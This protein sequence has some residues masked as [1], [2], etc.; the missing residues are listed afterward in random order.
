MKAPRTAFGLIFLTLTVSA[1]AWGQVTAQMHGTVQDSTGAAVPAATITVTQTQT[2]A[3]RTASSGANGGYVFT[4]L[5]IGPYRMEVSKDGFN[6]YVQEGIVLQ[7]NSDPLITVP[8]VVGTVNEQVLV[9]A[10]ATQVE[11]RASGVGQ[12]VENQRILELP[13]NGRNVTDLITLAGA[14]VETQET[15]DRFFAGSPFIGIGGGIPFGTSYTLDGANNI[16]FLTGVTMP[17]PFP[18]AV[19]EF[20]VET[21]GLTAEK[22]MSSSVSMVTKSGTNALHGDLFYFIRNGAT[23]GRPYSSP[24]DDNLKRNQFGG[25]IGGAIVPNRLFFFGGY[26][27]TTIRQFVYNNPTIIATPDMIRGDFTAFASPAC[28]GRQITM[29]GG[30]V[31]NKIDPAKFSPPAVV[32]AQALLDTQDSPPDQC[33]RVTYGTPTSRNDQQYVAKIDYQVSDRHSMFGRFVTSPQKFTKSFDLTKNLLTAGGTGTDSLAHSYTFGD[34]FVVNPAMVNAFRMAFNRVGSGRLANKW[35][36]WCTAGVKNFYCEPEEEFFG[37]TTVVGGFRTGQIFWN[38]SGWRPTNYAI[39][40][41]LNWV[42]GAHQMTIGFGAWQGRVYTRADYAN[43][44]QMVFNPQ[45]TGLGMGDFMTGN[46][47][48]LFQGLPN[49]HQVK[50]NSFD[51]YITDTWK[52]N[53]RLTI[54]AGLRYEPFLPQTVLNGA[55]YNFDINRFMA[56]TKSSVFVNAPAGFYYP[57]D[58][59]FPGM[60]GQ[61]RRWNQFAPR[62]GFAFDPTGDGRTSLRASWALGY[63]FNSGIWREDASGSNPWGGRSIYTRLPGGLSDPWNGY[64]GGNPYPYTVNKNVTFPLRGAFISAPYDFKTPNSYSWNVNLQHQLGSSW[65]LS[66][67]YMGNRTTHIWGYNA[68][69]AADPTVS[70]ASSANTDARRRLSLLNAAE[71]DFVG[72]MSEFDDGGVQ[73]YHAMLLSIQRRFSRGFS[74]SGNYT[75]SHCIGPLTDI[76]SNGPPADETWTVVGNREFDRGN[77]VADRRH[78]FN[79]TAVAETPRFSGATMRALGSGWKI[80]G[81]YRVTSG[82][83]VSIIM[84][85]DR[86]LTGITRQRPDQVMSDVILDGSG[87]YG[88]QYFNPAAFA[89]QTPGTFGNIGYNSV[90][91]PGWWNLDMSLSRAFQIRERVRFELRGEAFNVTNSYRTDNPGS[92]AGTPGANFGTWDNTAQ[93]GKILMVKDS[94][95]MQFAMKF[96]F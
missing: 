74:V 9:E 92:G 18:D 71:G 66:A 57:G 35:F 5:P 53:Q 80:S 25:T 51:L 1:I 48:T 77:C 34:T 85:T 87:H 33:G 55:V 59:G 13:L 47:F 81:I 42:R 58:P 46:M 93:F 68:I 32:V 2:G 21:S 12:V 8:L 56:G 88:S 30:F 54:N 17:V 64:P 44:A 67:T 91:A 38:T 26:Q 11:T 86:Q 3:V 50:Q 83:P 19:E 23:N 96:V 37:F 49:V 63:V 94:R 29:R 52:V 28:N 20:K 6:K 43:P 27:G 69:N 79:L 76:N 22:G 39:N 40:D 45:I 90:T 78:L 36:S 65:L 31:N 16:N 41:D 75:L 10:N 60:T 15:N 62:I 24:N 82:P 84:T 95:V 7:V 70:G 72:P 4:N 73:I 61:N 14:S 89:F